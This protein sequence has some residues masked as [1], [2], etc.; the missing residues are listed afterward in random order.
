MHNQEMEKE[1]M[2]I[3]RQTGL[4]DGQSGFTSVSVDGISLEANMA[5][6]TL[7]RETVKKFLEK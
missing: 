1:L 6:T 5:I 3:S 4:I 7:L 2:Q